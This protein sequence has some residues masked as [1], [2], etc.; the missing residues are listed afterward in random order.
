MLTTIIICTLIQLGIRRPDVIASLFLSL[1]SLYPVEKIFGNSVA[2]NMLLTMLRGNASRQNSEQTNCPSGLPIDS[3]SSSPLLSFNRINDLEKL[4]MG[5]GSYV[6]GNATRKSLIEKFESQTNTKVLFIDHGFGTECS[7]NI[8]FMSN[9]KSL[10]LQDSKSF[11]DELQKCENKDISLIINTPGGSLT[12]AE[13]IV[14]ALLNHNGKI[15][16]YIPYVSASAGM[17]IALASDKIYIGKNAFCGPID[18]QYGMLSAVSIVK[19]CDSYS[20]DRNG[21]FS[22]VADALCLL[23]SQAEAAITRASNVIDKIVTSKKSVYP[24]DLSRFKLEMLYG[25]RNHDEPIFGA[26]LSLMLPNVLL[27]MPFEITE[28]Y[29]TF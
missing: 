14:N 11:I 25:G 17:T 1:L 13:V 6:I 18:P 29:N 7:I 12:A 4:M 8:P 26:D 5:K 2:Y 19:F 22:F 21:S 27:D 9:Q 3:K 24:T 16:T 28:I 10:T 15:T 20:T 23:K